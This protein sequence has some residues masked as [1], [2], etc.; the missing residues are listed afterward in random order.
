MMYKLTLSALAFL[1]CAVLC[2]GCGGEKKPDGMPKLVPV[3]VTITQ[4]GA[5]LAEALV[6]FY[7]STEANKQWSCGGATDEQ[8]VI[9]VMTLGKHEGMAPDTYKVTV[10][11]TLIENPQINEDDPPGQFY[12]LVDKKYMLEN[13]TDLTITVTDEKNQTFTLDVGDAVKIPQ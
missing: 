2:C 12:Q 3:S 13:T 10:M 6:S 5:P 1:C 11:K 8:G 7:P 4:G 9:K